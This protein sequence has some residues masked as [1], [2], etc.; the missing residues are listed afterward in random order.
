MLNV[1]IIGAST[2]DDAKPDLTRCWSMNRPRVIV[3]K[4]LG[5]NGE[6]KS[7]SV[8]DYALHAIQTGH[9]MSVFA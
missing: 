2:R 9:L 4:A 5:V 3:V 1:E 7:F 6:W 8:M